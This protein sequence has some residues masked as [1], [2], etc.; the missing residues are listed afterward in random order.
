MKSFFKKLN[1]TIIIAVMLVLSIFGAEIVKFCTN[2]NN[3]KLQKI[4]NAHGLLAESVTKTK[5]QVNLGDYMI[6][7]KTMVKTFYG[8]V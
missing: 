7:G 5:T 6:L 2:L 8:D 1:S 3:L 4:A